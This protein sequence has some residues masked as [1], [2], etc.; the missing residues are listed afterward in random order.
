M[1]KKK[2]G[3]WKIIT[4]VIAVLIL[5]MAAFVFLNLPKPLE[6]NDSAY[7][8]SQ[9]SDGTYT[10]NCDNGIVQVQ[11]DVDV[12]D[13]F[14]TDVR[15]IRHQNGLGSTAEIIADDI[16]RHQSV[17]V[18][19]VSGATMSSKTILKAVEKALSGSGE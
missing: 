19:A 10:G 16:V 13:H 18:D 6:T 7:D 17:E 15:I 9:L 11:V 14:I 5:G 2:R 3:H 1:I 8:L 4:T 12:Q